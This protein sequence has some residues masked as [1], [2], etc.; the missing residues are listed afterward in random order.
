MQVGHVDSHW[1]SGLLLYQAPWLPLGMIQGKE[2]FQRQACPNPSACACRC[3]GT[4][5]GCAEQVALGGLP[6]EYGTVRRWRLL[7]CVV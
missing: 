1:G 7:Q 6:N 2:V 5:W 3:A 4:Q